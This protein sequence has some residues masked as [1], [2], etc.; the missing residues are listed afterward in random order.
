MILGLVGASYEPAF[1]RYIGIDYSG[2]QTQ[3][4]SHDS[5]AGSDLPIDRSYSPRVRFAGQVG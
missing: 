5:K 4:G 1:E 2:A 3:I